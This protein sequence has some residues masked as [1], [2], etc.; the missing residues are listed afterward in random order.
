MLKHPSEIKNE[1]RVFTGHRHCS[2]AESLII[3]ENKRRY[4]LGRINSDRI[5]S[6]SLGIL[7]GAVALHGVHVPRELFQWPI[8]TPEDE[9]AV[10]KV[11]RSGEMSGFETTLRF[12]SEFSK[13]QDTKFVLA[14]NTGTSAIQAALYALGV[15]AGDEVVC[16]SATYWASAAPALSLGATVRFVDINAN[17]LCIDP[18][19]L[20]HRL[21]PRTKVLIVVHNFGHP[22]DM[23]AILAITEPLGIAVLEDVSH[24]HGGRYKGKKLGTFGAA[25]AMSVMSGKALPAGEGGVLVTNDRSIYENALSWGHYLRGQEEL[26]DPCLQR[27]SGIPLGGCKNRMQQLNSAIASVQLRHFDFRERRIRAA[28]NRFWD[29]LD[30][31]PG[32]RPHRVDET[33]GST[34][35]GWY[36]PHGLYVSE[37]LG[38][39]SLSRYLSAIE[40]E[41]VGPL[42]AGVNLPLHLHPI[43]RDLDVYGRGRPTN[44]QPS[45]DLPVTEGIYERTFHVPWF[46]YDNEEVIERY[47]MAFWKISAHAEELLSDDTG[48]PPE[49]GKWPGL[50]SDK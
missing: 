46:K 44:V 24:A 38:G 5:I 23:D 18:S 50:L 30:G 8:I 40:A 41:G 2:S 14:H 47:A 6:Q 13:W 7:G 32:V 39:L 9:E 31:C 1:F 17:T 45:E 16:Q 10:L 34:M 25:A 4:H 42:K 49:F 19:D 28:M 33:T 15:R 22:A 26:T 21:T 3:Y 35:G 43:F 20:K 36:S 27:S 12:E 48:N 37:E 11:L 29:L